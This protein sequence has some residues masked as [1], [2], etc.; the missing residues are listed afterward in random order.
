MLIYTAINVNC[1]TIDA[2]NGISILINIK[3]ETWN[4][5]LIRWEV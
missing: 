5:V 1:L 2:K 3:I 4:F